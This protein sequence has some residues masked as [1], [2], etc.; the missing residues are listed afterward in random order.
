MSLGAFKILFSNC[1]IRACYSESLMAFKWLGP[2][3]KCDPIPGEKQ[4]SCIPEPHGD[5]SHSP[6]LSKMT[7]SSR[8]SSEKWGILL[9]HSTR[10]K[11]CLSA[12]W[13]MFVTGS[14]GCQ[15]KEI[16][17]LGE[18]RARR[19]EAGGTAEGVC[20]FPDAGKDPKVD[21]IRR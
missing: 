8:G 18:G 20:C 3:S 15:G 10:V 4:H 12:A 6:A 11:S 7:W 2:K 13:H 16:K 17:K 1:I 9:A 5:T 21:V 14:L 19:R